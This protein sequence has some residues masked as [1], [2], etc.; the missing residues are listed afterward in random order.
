MD[1][2]FC[3]IVAGEI[4]SKKVY[5]NEKIYAFYDISP[6]APVH[7]LVIPKCHIESADKIDENNSTA[8][9]AVFE[10]IPEIAKICG[11]ENGYRV[12]T[13]VGENGCQSVKHMHFHVL[14]GE[15]LSE[16]MS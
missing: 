10:A 12:V 11:L 16:K 1:C 14:G 2:L 8:V 5:E 4:P 13:N 9:S 3:K 15:K 6:Q 7:V